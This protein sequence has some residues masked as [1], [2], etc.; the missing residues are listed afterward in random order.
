MLWIIK[1]AL[2]YFKFVTFFINIIKLSTYW[3]MLIIDHVFT[4]LVSFYEHWGK[5]WY[6][7]WVKNFFFSNVN[8]GQWINV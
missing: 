2:I 6:S 5:Y 8:N 7:L 1:Y 3:I 4:F